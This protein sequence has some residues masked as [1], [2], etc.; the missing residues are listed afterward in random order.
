MSQREMMSEQHFMTTLPGDTGKQA[1]GAVPFPDARA[2]PGLLELSC[3]SRPALWG[4]LPVL[5]LGR[6]STG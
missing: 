6:S 2:A 3:L 5:S 1:G 4:T